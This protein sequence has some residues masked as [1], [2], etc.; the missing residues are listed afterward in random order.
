MN[1][2]PHKR[3]T[4]MK[5]QLLALLTIIACTLNAAAYDFKVNGLCYNLNNDGTSVS[6]AARYTQ[7]NSYPNPYMAYAIAL[8]NVVIPSSVTYAGK[9]YTV[10]SIGANAFFSSN[11]TSVTIPNSVTS[12]GREVFSGC[13]GLKNVTIGYSVTSIGDRAFYS[14]GSLTSVTIP[15]S[16]TS[17]GNQAFYCCHNL[18]N[19]TIGKSVATIGTEAFDDTKW[20]SNQPNG[21]VY[22]GPVAYKYRGKIP[23]G[24]NIVIREGTKG[25]STACFIGCTGLTNITIPNS[26]TNIGSD[27]FNNTT[28]LDNQPDGLVYAG[29]VAYQYKGTMPSGSNI[30]IREGTKSISAYCFESCSGLK[31][32]TIPNSVTSI[33]EW[34]FSDCEELTGITIGSSLN[35]IGEGA[36]YGCTSLTR[37]NISDIKAWGNIKFDDYESNPLYYAH[38]LFL[39]NNEIKNLVIPNTVKSI[40]DGAFYGC[41]SLTSV[42]IPNTVTSI[43]YGA[44]SECSNLNRVHISDIKAWCNID[45]KAASSNPLAYAKHLYLNANEIKDLVL[46]NSLTTIGSF[47]FYGCSGLKSVTIPNSVLSIGNEAFYYCTGLTKVAIGNSVI[48]I[49]DK[50]FSSCSSLTSVTIPNSVTS[51]G[52]EAFDY[53]TGLTNITIPN[54]VTSIGTYAFNR[55][56]WFNN[57]PAGL[58]YAGL[59]A[60]EYKETM[61]SGTKIVIKQGTKAIADACFYYC[62]GLTE[63]TLPNSLIS[64]GKEAFSGCSSLTSVTIPN[65]VTE[66]GVSAFEDCDGLTRVSIP[67]SVK[68]IRKRAFTYCDNL[69]SV[70]VSDIAAWCNIEIE[71]YN[72]EKDYGLFSS[73]PLVSAEHLYLNDQEI[74]DLVIPNTVTSISESVFESCKGLTSLTIPNSITSIGRYA[75]WDCS[76]LTDIKSYPD[77]TKV[78]L[79]S[80]VFYNVPNS[81]TLHVLPQYLSAYKAADQWKEFNIVGDLTDSTPG[82]LNGDGSVNAGDVSE[83]YSAILRGDNNPA[84]DVNGDGSINAGDISEIYRVILNQ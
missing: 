15:N 23:S 9:T 79:G 18:T 4:S 50:A 71:F 56:T 57:K 38:R 62:K 61:P 3:T 48:G 28:W 84:F 43:G 41:T 12:I 82:D 7:S 2:T 66:I 58:V 31:N 36:F 25:I 55:T 17:I 53:C 32:I 40:G 42:T 69:K 67:A 81:C 45:F 22:A 11:L 8:N 72:M 60:Y 63:V 33:G 27:A 52:R 14:C 77:P 75:F 5:H 24:A 80:S 59:V 64:I 29:L 54:S 16:V 21:L 19:V 13:T 10:T 37:V 44:F 47:V 49:G 1:I 20:L 30:V 26:V 51:I 74:T 68:Y 76:N 78:T 65:S 46:P 39:N 35:S 70:H 83:Q 6:V 34:A 73:N